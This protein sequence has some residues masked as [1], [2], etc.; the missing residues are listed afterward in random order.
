MDLLSLN[1]KYN[2]NL[3]EI[4]DK[5]DKYFMLFFDKSGKIIDFSE[6]L[7]EK[8]GF[9]KQELTGMSLNN[10]FD[11]RVVEINKKLNEINELTAEIN[12]LKKDKTF[13][14]TKTVF[15][16]KNDCIIA[17]SVPYIEYDSL[18]KLNNRLVKTLNAN[19][20]IL[21]IQS[22]LENNIFS[23][24]LEKI[25]NIVNYDKA[26][27]M[28]LEGDTLITKRHYGFED[29]P[30]NHKKNISNKDKIL[31]YVMLT[32]KS[33]IDGN[34][35]YNG[36]VL[37]EIGLNCKHEFS[38]II[39][40]LKIRDTVYGF[41]IIILNSKDGYDEN[42]IKILEALSLTSSYLIKDVE[43]TQ[44]FKMQLKIFKDNITERTKTL[45][46]IKEQNKKI[47]EADKIKNEFLASMSHELRTPLNAI[48][49]FSEALNLKIF[50]ELNDKQS[51]YIRDIN[52]SGIHLLGMIN[53]LLDLSKI[54]S[55]KIRLDKENFNVK[56]AINEALNIVAPLV[57]QKNQNIKFECKNDSLEICAD[58]RK[59]HQILYNLLSNAIKFTP[60]NGNIFIKA[61]KDK[62]HLSVAVKDD[63]IGIAPE[64][65]KKI[66]DKFQQ[67]DNSFSGRYGSTGLGLTIT[68]ELI[69]LHK[70]E[71][72]LESK[73][74]TGSVFI[75]KI[76]VK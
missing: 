16:K 59:F 13:L 69:K 21:D 39:S 63:G 36:S 75:I 5:S 60:E 65:H 56:F 19:T 50:G 43:L 76:P 18:K 31:N 17:V 72:K 47:L 70:G 74:G 62:N 37:D 35:E 30:E 1:S 71:I 2:I 38:S 24:L 29:Y 41:I 58:R 40:P 6:K 32:H 23:L 55:G 48:I 9:F 67:V 49:G 61:F 53:D 44:V 54:E 45:E 46:L 10:I 3:S 12:L 57:K 4:F 51:E 7:P 25:K 11:F 27:I 66:F 73:L 22:S 14:F 34:N 42:D 52:S 15:T 68:K 8:L 64:F 33:I 26:L 20:E 28:L